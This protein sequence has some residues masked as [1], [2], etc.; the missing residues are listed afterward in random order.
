VRYRRGVSVRVVVWVALVLA[1]WMPGVVHAQEGQT[2][3]L[4]DG[5]TLELPPPAPDVLALPPPPYEDGLPPPDLRLPAPPSVQLRD[6]EMPG[7]PAQPGLALEA[8]SGSP[9]AEW[10]GGL[11]GYG[12]GG[13]AGAAIIAM[14]VDS[15]D[16]GAIVVGVTLGAAATM[17]GIAAGVDIAGDNTGGNGSL[18]SAFAGQ[19]VGGLAS[20]VVLGLAFAADPRGDGLGVPIAVLGV[21]CLPVTGA[22]IG[23][24]MSDDLQ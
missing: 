21:I 4:G 14:M 1:S 20:L 7:A 5:V 17:L 18:W 8:G 10:F 24:G 13:L 11:L 22:V 3:E 16:D 6:P 2:V 12:I 15:N 9:V 19:F 23:Y